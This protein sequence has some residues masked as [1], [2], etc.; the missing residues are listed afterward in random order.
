MASGAQPSTI[1][2][3]ADTSSKT[4]DGG[5]LQQLWPET[6]RQGRRGQERREA[7]EDRECQESTAGKNSAY[8]QNFFH[9]LLCVLRKDKLRLFWKRVWSLKTSNV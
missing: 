7:A 3:T 9:I 4:G 6:G 1:P 5:D 8:N 2:V